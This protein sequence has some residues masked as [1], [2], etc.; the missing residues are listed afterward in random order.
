M[1]IVPKAFYRLTAI[2]IKIPMVIFTEIEESSEIHTEPQET[3][4]IQR[5]FDQEE[6]N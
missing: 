1:S 6:Q 5:N 3:P 2:P 4:N